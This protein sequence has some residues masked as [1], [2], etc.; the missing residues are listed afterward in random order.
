[1]KGNLTLSNEEVNLFL[2]A[3]SYIADIAAGDT[4]QVDYFTEYDRKAFT[5]LCK[6]LY[7]LLKDIHEVRFG[8]YQNE[9]N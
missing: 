2:H 5:V 6:M 7:P 3:V 9:H 8:G 1:M 4:T